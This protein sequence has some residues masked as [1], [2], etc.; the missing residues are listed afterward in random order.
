VRISIFFG[1]IPVLCNGADLV[2]SVPTTSQTGAGASYAPVSAFGRYV[3]FVSSANNL[4]TNDR[5]RQLD[6]FLH[7]LATGE[8]R[9][10]STGNGSAG[11]PSFYGYGLVYAAEIDG[12][13]HIFAYDQNAGVNT[14][15]TAGSL[16]S[17]NGPPPNG[18]YRPIA[19]PDGNS[20]VFES[21]ATNLVSEPDTNGLPDLF[22][23]SLHVESNILVSAG[24][25]PR[26]GSYPRQRFEASI[27]PDGQRVAFVS[28]NIPAPTTNSVI[29][30][31]AFVRNMEDGSLMWASTNVESILGSAAAEYVCSHPLLSLDRD[32]VVFKVVAVRGGTNGLVLH[33]NLQSGETIVIASNSTPHVP[34][35]LSPGG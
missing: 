30:T 24:A 35:A 29:R 9:L 19:P 7:D 5:G 14:Q 33:H 26:G 28:R 20:V 25:V 18:S 4:V 10:V 2:S 22:M 13:S 17:P 1:L 32:I 8:T 16:A 3:A 12:I 11:Y 27:S 31:E 21:T 23:R 6:L 15:L 34:C